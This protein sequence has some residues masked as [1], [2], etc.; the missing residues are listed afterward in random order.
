[1]EPDRELHNSML[2][3]LDEARL[4]VQRGRLESLAIFARRHNQSH[5]EWFVSSPEA[6]VCSLYGFALVALQRLIHT[7]SD[8][9]GGSEPKG[10]P[11]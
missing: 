5:I 3:M 6:D 9:D 1:V 4:E 2:Q 11:S 7:K 10:K 8:S